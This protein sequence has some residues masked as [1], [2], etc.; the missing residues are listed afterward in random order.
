MCIII[1]ILH[2]ID[3]IIYRERSKHTILKAYFQVY[4]IYDIHFPFDADFK[5]ICIYFMSNFT[6]VPMIDADENR[7]D[8]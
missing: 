8:I 7:L 1:S 2:I 5:V 3:N 6:Y 4:T